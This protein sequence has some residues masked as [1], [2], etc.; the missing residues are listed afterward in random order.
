MQRIDE[1]K[2]DKDL[3]IKIMKQADLMQYDD[4]FDEEDFY[5]GKRGGKKYQV[6]LNVKGGNVIMGKK[7]K[8]KK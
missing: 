1:Q 8:N 5:D 4:D 7:G 2:E 3:K 6:D